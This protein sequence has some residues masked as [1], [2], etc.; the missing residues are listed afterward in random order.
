M[1]FL[2]AACYAWLLQGAFGALQ[3]MCEDSADMLSSDEQGHSSDILLPKFLQFFDHSH[4]KIRYDNGSLYG[5]LLWIACFFFQ[6]DRP[7]LRK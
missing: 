7:Q 6:I 5:S 2:I 3:K 4:A 1:I